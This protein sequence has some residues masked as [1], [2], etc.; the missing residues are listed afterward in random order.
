MIFLSFPRAVGTPLMEVTRERASDPRRSMC[1]RTTAGALALIASILAGM[2]LPLPA[3]AQLSEAEEAEAQVRTLLRNL[4]LALAH[5]NAT[6]NYTV[7][8]D[9]ASPSFAQANSA[10]HLAE[11]YAPMRANGI[12]LMPLALVDPQFTQQVALDASGRLRMIGFFPTRPLRVDF[13]LG[14]EPVGGSWRLADIRV[15]TVPWQEEPGPGPEEATGEPEGAT[16]EATPDGS[17]TGIEVEP[18]ASTTPA[19]PRLPIPRPG[20]AQ[21]PGAQ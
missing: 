8:R 3:H 17:G 16:A 21:A 19:D 1:R 9:L 14:F 7:V 13:N 10:A 5:A 2:T 18:G 4:M 11:V 20:G 12:S 15:D 6:G